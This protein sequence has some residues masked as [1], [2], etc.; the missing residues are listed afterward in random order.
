M[1]F[2][3]PPQTGI[4]GPSKP[5]ALAEEAILAQETIGADVPAQATHEAAIEP[6]SPPKNP[7][8][9]SFLYFVFT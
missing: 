2:L 8:P 3:P 9:W 7:A 1:G 5:I 6:S 4:P